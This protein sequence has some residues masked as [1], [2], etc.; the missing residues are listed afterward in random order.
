[1]TWSP[2]LHAGH[3][4]PDIDDDAGA[5]VAEDGREQAFGVGAGERELVGVTDARGLDLDQHLA[6][7]RA[8]ELDV[9]DHERLGLLQCDGGTGFHG[10]VLLVVVVGTGRSGGCIKNAVGVESCRG[11]RWRR[12]D[13]AAGP[14]SHQ[15]VPTTGQ[16]LRM[17]SCPEL[18][19]PF[20]KNF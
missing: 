8:V 6:G 18:R 1:M 20:R 4:R 19:L 2:F 10:G 17:G 14:G 16:D 11:V 7:F 9:R 13:T 15:R 3:A 12:S 5:L